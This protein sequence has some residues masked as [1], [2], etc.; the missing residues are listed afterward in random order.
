M[1]K[2]ILDLHDILFEQL[3]RLNNE[4]IK[5]ED[6]TEQIRRAEAISKVAGQIIN[7]GRFVLEARKVEDEVE[8]PEEFYTRKRLKK[9]DEQENMKLPE[10]G[11]RKALLNRNTF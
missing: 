3:E 1:A 5:N 10:H 9:S 2:T 7:N 6:L 8:L 4:N 11:K